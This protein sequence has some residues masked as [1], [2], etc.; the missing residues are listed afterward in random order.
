MP[1]GTGRCRDHFANPNSIMEQAE[2]D[3]RWN[4]FMRSRFVYIC[5][6][7]IDPVASGMSAKQRLLYQAGRDLYLADRNAW[8]VVVRTFLFPVLFEDVWLQAPENPEPPSPKAVARAVRL[9][10]ALV[11]R[12]DRAA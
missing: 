1:E 4:I 9:F 5:I 2:L 12:P 6:C 8:F 10:R 7:G 11:D 3:R